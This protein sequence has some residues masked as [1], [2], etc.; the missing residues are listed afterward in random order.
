MNILAIDP[1]PVE[2]GVVIWHSD[3]IV[4]AYKRSNKTI[5]DNMVSGFLVIIERP[6]FVSSKTGLSMF[7]TCWEAGRFH[8]AFDCN[9]NIV[10]SIGRSD[11]KK[12]LG[13][14]DTEI[15]RKLLQ[16]YGKEYCKLLK[17]DCWQ[18]FALIHVYNNL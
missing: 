8:Q 17:A 16:E 11:I 18:A 3:G 7:N 13:K 15:R 10:T 6:D 9:K 2:S 5:R 14:T 12:R 4:D 1:G